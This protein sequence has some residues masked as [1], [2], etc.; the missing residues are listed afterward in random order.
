[1]RDWFGVV[2]AVAGIA[3]VAGSLTF[4]LGEAGGA[5]LAR[6]GLIIAIA[7]APYLALVGAHHLSRTA[8]GRFICLTG[9]TALS[10]FWV[11]AFGGLVWW[12]AAPDGQNGLTLI[13]IPM[14]MAGLGIALLLAAGLGDWIARRHLAT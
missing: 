7:S 12:N 6:N 1:M 2:L 3:L 10:L 8:T 14:M 11:W 4:G 13:L 5:G 9:L